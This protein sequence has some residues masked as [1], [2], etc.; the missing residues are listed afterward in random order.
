[1]VKS[2]KEGHYSEV[3]TTSPCSLRLRLVVLLLLFKKRLVF[4]STGVLSSTF[5]TSVPSSTTT[6]D[7]APA[8]APA[9][10]T[11]STTT[12]STTTGSTTTGVV[13]GL[14]ASLYYLPGV[15]KLKSTLVTSTAK[16]VTSVY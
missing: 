5:T 14:Q 13:V 1:L 8:S 12:G 10:T 9:S 6:S 11:G 15:P 4:E 2:F 7:P 3:S 16:P